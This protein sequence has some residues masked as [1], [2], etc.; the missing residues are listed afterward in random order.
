M[1]RPKNQ[2]PDQYAMQP[3]W[4]VGDRL[5]YLKTGEVGTVSY[6]SRPRGYVELGG[7]SIGILPPHLFERADDSGE[8]S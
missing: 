1:S 5:R 2:P 7:T 6:V 4:K 8:L 3:R